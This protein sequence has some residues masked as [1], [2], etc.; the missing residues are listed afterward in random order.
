MAL[1]DTLRDRL[2]RS[3]RAIIAWNVAANQLNRIRHRPGASFEFHS[4]ADTR[5]AAVRTAG[6]VRHMFKDYLDILPREYDLAGQRVVEIGPG[7]Q[8]GVALLFLAHGAASVTC[9]DKYRARVN[10]AFLGMLYEELR[11]DL[12]PEQQARVSARGPHGGPGGDAFRSLDDCPLER[13]GA[14]LEPSSAD[15]VVSRSVLEYLKQPDE[16]FR[17]VDALLARGGAMAHVVDCRD[18]GLFSS[19]G[20]HPLEFLTVPESTY[21]AMTSHTYRPNRWRIAQFRRVLNDM[22]YAAVTRVLRIAGEAGRISE[23]P[24]LPDS[25]RLRLAT[26]FRDLPDAD[27]TTDGFSLYAVKP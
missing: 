20:F 1:R 6:Y 18:D 21:S 10:P 2:L 27:L 14:V 15:L 12:T 26:P 11:R 13:A 23:V 5:E 17:V 19:H 8:F 16:A 7:D 3:R 24:A 22:G 9:L 25:L 4:H